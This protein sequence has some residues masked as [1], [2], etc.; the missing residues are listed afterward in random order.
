MK[1]YIARHG[2]SEANVLKVISNRDLPHGLTGEGRQQARILAERLRLHPITSVYA[3]PIPRAKQT[4][5]IVAGTLQVPLVLAD[6]LREPDCGLLEGRGDS[7]A[8]VS[9]RHWL[10]TWL[11]G[12]R[13]NE[14]PPEAETCE[15]LQRRFR[16]VLT[17]LLE[18]FGA[19]GKEFV[20]ITHGEAMLLSLPGFVDGL[21]VE[22]IFADYLEHGA[23]LE[24]S[25]LNG[26][27]VF[28]KAETAK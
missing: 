9:Q 7:E 26:R 19:T 13:L 23:I 8:W 27:L 5:E 11:A 16:G 28:T 10:E 15:Q 2:E 12:Q 3:S 24:V 21:A 6:G 4:G 14:G 17:G 22:H 25:G 1:L 18:E 20:L